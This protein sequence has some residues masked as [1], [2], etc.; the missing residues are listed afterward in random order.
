MGKWH[1]ATILGIDRQVWKLSRIRPNDTLRTTPKDAE[2]QETLT[3]RIGELRMD[4][5]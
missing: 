3:N 2:G 5:C 4:S 1:Y